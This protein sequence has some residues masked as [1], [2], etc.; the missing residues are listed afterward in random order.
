MNPDTLRS[1]P[2]PDIPVI[3]RDAESDSELVTD[4]PLAQVIDFKKVAAERALGLIS[5]PPG[6]LSAET[7]AKIEASKNAPRH[8][9][10][11]TT[12]PENF[13]GDTS[14]VSGHPNNPSTQ[15]LDGIGEALNGS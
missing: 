14:Q 9:E 13:K 3:P 4:A 7:L 12:N 11:V 1:T 8:G 6:I 10:V 2:Q 5:V 15:I